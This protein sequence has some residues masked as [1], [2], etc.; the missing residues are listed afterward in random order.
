[1]ACASALGAQGIPVELLDSGLL[2]FDPDLVQV[3]AVVISRDGNRVTG[4]TANDFEVMQ[5]GKRQPIARFSYVPRGGRKL[6]ILVDD[7]ALEIGD[8]AQVRKALTRFIDEEVRP[9]DLVSLIYVSRGSGA[10][11]QFTSDKPTLHRAMEQAYWRPMAAGTVLGDI[12]L[13]REMR[14]ILTDLRGFPGRKSLLVVAPGMRHAESLDIR[15]MAGLASRASVV[16][17]S[18]NAGR[19]YIEPPAINALAAA[20]GG[21]TLRQTIRTFDWLRESADSSGYYLIGWRPGDDAS[22][23]YHRIQIRTRDRKLQVR[24]RDGYAARLGGS[25]VSQALTPRAQMRRALVSPFRSGDLEVRLT[26][27]FVRREAMGSFVDL[28]VHIAPE[29]VRFERGANGCW[30]AR[31]ELARALWALNP[32]FAPS[33]RVNTDLIEVNACGDAAERTRREGIVAAVRERAASPG[34]YQVRVAVRNADDQGTTVPVGSAAQ[35]LV[36]PDPR[37]G[38]PALSG[39]SL[40]AGNAPTEAGGEV[41]YRPA[42]DGDAAVRRFSRSDEVRYAFQA[43]GLPDDVR[44]SLLR[45]GEELQVA[46][47]RSGD[48]LSGR[49]PVAGLTTG[50]YVLHVSAARGKG[51]E[52]TDEFVDFEIH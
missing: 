36:V 31:L 20:T 35:F 1:M 47:A 41:A 3:D 46:T 4:L 26:A 7:L 40:W 9:D 6:V 2:R 15:E 43:F 29:G 17:H 25:S 38:A 32:G 8:Y 5:D 42:A 23:D 10:L 33:D 27:N 45:D 50:A 49:L 18:M 44:V 30:T 24:T 28:L 22:T 16:I 52:R 12:P 37:K 19:A 11:Q 48:A 39:I 34:A 14:D 51:A 13:D 21:S